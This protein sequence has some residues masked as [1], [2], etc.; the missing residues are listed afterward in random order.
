[1]NSQGAIYI[2]GRGGSLDRGLGAHLAETYGV[3][4]GLSLSADWFKRPHNEQV[5][6]VRVQLTDAADAGRPVIAN[7]YGS[8]LVMLALLDAP[9]LGTSVMLLSPVLGKAVIGGTYHRPPGGKSFAAALEGH[10]AKPSWLELYIGEADPHYAPA[11]WG[12]LGTAIKPD[13]QE[14]LAGE[15]HSLSKDLVA[16]LVR[17]FMQR[18][19]EAREV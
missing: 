9:P 3:V 14:V 1:V 12:K 5:A 4:H 11:T 13:R 8:Y 19:A 7:S 10:I 6:L 16:G 15:G 17:N 2:T 18:H